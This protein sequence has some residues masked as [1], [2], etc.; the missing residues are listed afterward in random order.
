[1]EVLLAIRYSMNGAGKRITTSKVKTYKYYN[2]NQ[3]ALTMTL[4]ITHYC[5]VGTP[6]HTATIIQLIWRLTITASPG[7]VT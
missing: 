5:V 4:V 2:I 3:P 6:Q 7:D 1:M